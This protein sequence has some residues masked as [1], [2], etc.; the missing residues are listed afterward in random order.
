MDW[1][2][3]LTGFVESTGTAGYEETR[4]RLQVDG[5][6]LISRVNGRSYGIGTLELIS[7]QALRERAHSGPLVPGVRSV[8]VVRG[9]ARQL[10]A[11]E[12]CA[13]AVFQVASQFNLLE[14]VG[15]DVT[16]ERGVTRYAGDGTQGPACAIAAGAATLYRNYFAAV[17]DAH[18]QTAARQLDGFAEL[19]HA[20]AHE[21]G[22]PSEA[23]WQMRNGYAMF[24]EDGILAM[25]DH[26]RGLD[27][28]QRDKLRE[29]LK[30]GMHWDVEVT[31]GPAAPGQV[32]S[33]AFCSALPVAYH[34]Y[35]GVPSA[36]WAPLATLV[37]EAAYEA[38]LWAAV[39]N[40]QRGGSRKVL[41]TELGGGAFGNDKSWIRSSM[42]RA[43]RLVQHHGIQA[44]VVSFG[45][46][47]RELLDWARAQVRPAG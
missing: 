1:F 19:G 7:L 42:Q 6:R 35:A 30:I 15:P 18:G 45:A 36:A 11:S 24:S 39:V 4:Q 16:P 23:L 2:E 43:L 34:G 21:L 9:D 22:R 41:L 12:P 47:P 29:R 40:A 28:K 46:P 33:Q 8:R 14:M 44:L 17:G 10:H 3:R 25:S 13:S 20:V 37:L 26:V 32:V 5:K 27:E 38:T 31:D